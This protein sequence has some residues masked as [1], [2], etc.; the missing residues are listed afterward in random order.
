MIGEGLCSGLDA[1][2]CKSEPIFCVF[3]ERLVCNPLSFV[4][5]KLKSSSLLFGYVLINRWVSLR[6]QNVGVFSSAF[7]RVVV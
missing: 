6:A 2:K 7:P 4:P 3:L 1:L 5:R